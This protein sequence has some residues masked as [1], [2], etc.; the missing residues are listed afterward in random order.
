MTYVS[1]AMYAEGSTDAEYLGVII[2]RLIADILTGADGPIPIIP[3][4]PAFKLDDPTRRFD[5]I[6]KSLCSGRE[7]F[8]LLFVHGDTGGRGLA[9]RIEDRTCALCRLVED[10]CG[11]PRDRCIVVAPNREIEAWTLADLD[12]IRQSFG[13]PQNMRIDSVPALPRQVENL[14]DPKR[15]CSEVLDAIYPGRRRTGKRWPYE[16]I[17]QT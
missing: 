12:A 2:P 4:M 15:S 11:F 7:A 8:H 13:L 5:L 10:L 16:V 1:W 17:A 6:S 14:E 3:D 9:A